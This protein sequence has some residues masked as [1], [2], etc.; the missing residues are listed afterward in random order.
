M[1]SWTLT[2]LIL[3]LLAAAAVSYATATTVRRRRGDLAVL[4]VLGMTGRQV[5]LVISVAVVS[6][7]LARALLGSA[8]GLVV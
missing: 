3:A 2:F 1:L 4:R 6:L 5:R 7:T 8:G